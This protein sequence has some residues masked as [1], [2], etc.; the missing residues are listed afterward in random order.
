MNKLLVGVVTFGAGKAIDKEG[1][2]KEVIGDDTDVMLSQ[3]LTDQTVRVDRDTAVIVLL[4]GNLLYHSNAPLAH[5][6][7]QVGYPT[8]TA[9]SQAFRREY[10]SPPATWRKTQSTRSQAS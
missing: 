2:I 3:D 5:V 4:A 10:G 1:F 9:F 7:E 6:A 8:D